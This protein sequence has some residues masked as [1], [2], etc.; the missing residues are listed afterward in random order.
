MSVRV[1]VW[2]SILLLIRVALSNIYY[3]RAFYYSTPSPRSSRQ[4]AIQ[5][6]QLH[7][8]WFCAQNFG[9]IGSAFRPR[10]TSRLRNTENRLNTCCGSAS[11]S[12]SSTGSVHSLRARSERYV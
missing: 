7:S 11:T 3:I 9:K 5:S 1:C 6:G 12:R 4:N 8:F 2:L 10:S